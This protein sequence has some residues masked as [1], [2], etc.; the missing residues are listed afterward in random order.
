MEKGLR[1]LLLLIVVVAA[2][3][4]TAFWASS[5]FFLFS[6]FQGPLPPYYLPGDLVF[7]YSAESI[8]SSVNIVLL[9][10]LL[11][12]YIS[13]YRKTRSEFTIG[14]IVFSSVFLLYALSSNPFL[15]AAFGFR[16]FGLGP[17]A[18]LPD[19]FT[20]GALLVLLWLS[21]RY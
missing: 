14:L 10:F 3:I 17:F 16:Q 12:T 13:I 7:F 11:G 9:I 20:F 8:V 1:T 18:L 21:L 4:L 15:T 5:R 2:T 19:L 6:F